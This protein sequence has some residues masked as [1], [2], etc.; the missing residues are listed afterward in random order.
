MSVKNSKYILPT[1]R[2]SLKSFNLFLTVKTISKLNMEYSVELDIKI[3][4]ISRRRSRSPDNAKFCRG[5][6]EVCKYLQ[7]SCA[8]IVLITKP[9]V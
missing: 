2:A 9:F 6:K 8:A 1:N 7:R 4:K 5:H 3:Q